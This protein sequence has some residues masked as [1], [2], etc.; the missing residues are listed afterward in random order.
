LA[1]SKHSDGVK[2][3][4]DSVFTAVIVGMKNTSIAADVAAQ[5]NGLCRLPRGSGLGRCD[6]IEAM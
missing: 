2:E 6:T 5:T 1:A 4:G 3:N